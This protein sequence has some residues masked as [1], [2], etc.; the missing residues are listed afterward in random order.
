MSLLRYEEKSLVLSHSLFPYTNTLPSVTSLTGK[1]YF[2]LSA[3]HSDARCYILY[4]ALS[5]NFISSPVFHSDSSLFFLS[6]PPSSLYWRA[7]NLHSWENRIRVDTLMH[8]WVSRCKN[9]HKAMLLVKKR[10]RQNF[11]LSHRKHLHVSMCY[12]LLALWGSISH[13]SHHHCHCQDS[14]CSLQGHRRWQW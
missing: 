7:K 8:T 2:L 5:S 13:L 10:E 4:L 14:L 6:C 3:F 1:K 11:S 9:N 12:L